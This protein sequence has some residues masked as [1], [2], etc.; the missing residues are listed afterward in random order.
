MKLGT[1]AENESILNKFIQY[2]AL[3]SLHC[4]LP[5]VAWMKGIELVKSF[6]KHK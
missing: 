3:H 4:Q 2:Y 6:D 1:L 5:V